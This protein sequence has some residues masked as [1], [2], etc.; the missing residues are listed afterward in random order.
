M[1]IQQMLLGAGGAADGEYIDNIFD[2]YLRIG[3]GTNYTVTNNLNLS[4]SGGFVWVKE[5][6]SNNSH[7]IFSTNIPDVSSK[8]PFVI[9]NTSNQANT[10]SNIDIQFNSNG[11]QWQG[12]DGLINQSSGNTY[13]DWSFRKCPGFVDV[14]TYLSLIHI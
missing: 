3:N 13:V 6:N 1:P 5:R 11:Y 7:A 4:G 12:D 8:R 14:V 10:T 2:T 9:T